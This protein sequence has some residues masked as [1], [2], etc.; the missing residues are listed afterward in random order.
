MKAIILAAGRGSRMKSLTQDRPKC[1]IKV[2]GKTLLDWQIEA[3]QEA[4]ISE[5]S[6]VTG[7][8]RELISNRGLTEFHNPHWAK[9]QMVTSLSYA[10]TWLQQGPCVV[11]YS[12]IFYSYEAPKSLMFCQARLALTYDP[13]WRKLWTMRFG[14]PLKDAE[15]F[16]LKHAKKLEEIGNSPRSVEEIE[17]QYMGL[18][19]FTPEGWD[20]VVRVRSDLT[21]QQ[22][23][24]MHMTGT[25]QEIIKAG[26]IEIEALPYEGEW[27][28]VD[29]EEDLSHY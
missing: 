7:Y 9:T 28:E 29:S 19:L 18:L 15:T 11:S 24:K 12:D 20:E 22:R 17:G 2:R 26:R 4:G 14:D 25:L 8:K 5:I 6:I 16:R 10:E 21:S 1:L 3:L 13:N 23:D 27:G